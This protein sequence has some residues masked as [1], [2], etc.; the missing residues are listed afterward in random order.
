MKQFRL[1]LV[2]G[3]IHETDQHP[4]GNCGKSEVAARRDG[5]GRSSTFREIILGN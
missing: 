3:A 5:L 1:R 2:A 4:L